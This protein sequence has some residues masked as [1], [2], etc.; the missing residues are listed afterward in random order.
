[1]YGP[2]AWF[3]KFSDV[4]RYEMHHSDCCKVLLIFY[5][6]DIINTGDDKKGIEFVF[7]ALPAPFSQYLAPL[8]PTIPSYSVYGKS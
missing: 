8:L 6:D 2:R 1:M 3:G 7:V 4:L 5:A